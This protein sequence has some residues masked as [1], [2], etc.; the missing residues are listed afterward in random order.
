MYRDAINKPEQKIL[1]FSIVLCLYFHLSTP[2]CFENEGGR[3]SYTKV[4]Q[5][6]SLSQAVDLQFYF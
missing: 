4:T 2:I 5:N 3:G 1:T 6:F